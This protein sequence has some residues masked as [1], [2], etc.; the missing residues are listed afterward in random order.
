MLDHTRI[1]IDNAKVAREELKSKRD[2]ALETNT[3]DLLTAIENQMNSLRDADTFDMA[4]EAVNNIRYLPFAKDPF[5]NF[6]CYSLSKKTISFYFHVEEK[7]IDT[8]LTLHGFIESLYM[9]S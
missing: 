7:F 8:E 4:M 9:N 6:F 3:L 2:A 5:G 1:T